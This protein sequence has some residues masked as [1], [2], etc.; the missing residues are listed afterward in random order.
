MLVIEHIGDAFGAHYELFEKVLT[1]C[2]EVVEVNLS[3][4]LF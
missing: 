4:L 1:Q 3:Y 2:T